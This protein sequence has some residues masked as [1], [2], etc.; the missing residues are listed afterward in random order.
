MGEIT[1]SPETLMRQA[2]MTASEYLMHGISEIDDVFGKGYAKEHPELLGAFIQAA[3]SDMN[4]ATIAKIH[5]E[6]IETLSLCRQGY[7]RQN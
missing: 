3:A 1:A 6:A 7:C 5:S 4:Y 2:W